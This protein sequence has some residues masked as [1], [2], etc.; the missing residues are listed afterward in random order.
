M[1][2]PS[3]LLEK[4][5]ALDR[6]AE[7]LVA[8]A[9]AEAARIEAGLKDQAAQAE[10]AADTAVRSEV[11]RRAAELSAEREQEIAAVH[12]ACQAE[13]ARLRALPAGK[14]HE[15]AGR[16]AERLDERG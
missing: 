16:V 3:E 13:L 7:H 5:V 11:E 1:P 4:L 2:L 9:R 8:E 6:R 15:L 14:L 10:R 12:E